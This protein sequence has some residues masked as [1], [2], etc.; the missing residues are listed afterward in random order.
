VIERSRS[1]AS[2]CETRYANGP[3]LPLSFDIGGPVHGSVCVLADQIRSD[4]RGLVFD[5]VIWTTH[6]KSPLSSLP[7]DPVEQVYYNFY[8]L[9]S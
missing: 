5:I 4:A 1:R 9:R 7:F 3:L 2:F 8:F 6:G